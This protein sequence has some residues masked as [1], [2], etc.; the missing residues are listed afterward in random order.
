MA[1]DTD[2]CR[3]GHDRDRHTHFHDRTYCGTCPR[4]FCIAFRKP[5]SHLSQAAA[6]RIH[7]LLAIIR[8]RT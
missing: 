6:Y 5:P 2:M 3:C 8:R 4:D 1:A 7:R